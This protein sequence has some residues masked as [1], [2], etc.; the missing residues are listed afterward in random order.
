[1]GDQSRRTS[2]EHRDV[3]GDRRGC[4]RD[5]RRGCDAQTKDGGHSAARR[6]HAANSALRTCS[7]R[8]QTSQVRLDRSNLF[9]AQSADIFDGLDVIACLA[10]GLQD[11]ASTHRRLR[12]GRGLVDQ[13][14]R[15]A[16]HPRHDGAAAGDL[17]CERNKFTDGRQDERADAPRN[18]TRILR[19][20]LLF[21]PALNLLPFSRV[22]RAHA[23]TRLVDARL[24]VLSVV[25][26]TATL[27]SGV[28]S[29][30][31]DSMAPLLCLCFGNH[32]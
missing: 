25:R 4:E 18:N 17:A 31:S 24:L 6:D 5:A 20:H 8:V 22:P 14:Q 1:M 2:Q 9:E 30:A 16:R 29:R 23:R 26:H 12:D 11:L 7:T 15:L 13:G 28:L 10:I 32:S 19:A 27:H 21:F 3:E